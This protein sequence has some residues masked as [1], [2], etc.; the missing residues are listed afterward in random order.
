M[1]AQ[2]L[3]ILGCICDTSFSLQLA[4]KSNKLEYF[5]QPAFSTKYYVKRQPY[6]PIFIL[7]IK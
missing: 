2:S 4:S 5:P 1:F 3:T 6:G 7:Q